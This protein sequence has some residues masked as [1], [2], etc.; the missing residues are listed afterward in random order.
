MPGADRRNADGVRFAEVDGRQSSQA[1]GKRVVADA[2]RFVDASLADAIEGTPDWR[3]RYLGPVRDLV[4]LGTRSAKDALRIAADGLDSLHRNVEFAYKDDVVPVRE[5]LDGSVSTPFETAVLQ[6]HNRSRAGELTIPYKGEELRGDALLGRL[7]RWQQQGTLEPSAAR[8]I[9]EVV[10]TPE[11]LDLSD[12]HVVLLGAAAE[13]GPLDRLCRWGANVYAVDVPWPGIWRRIVASAM[14]GGGKLHVPMRAAPSQDPD[15]IVARGGADIL[16]DLPGLAAWLGGFE[17]SL[18]VG[19]YVYVD[20]STFVLLAAAAD[21]LTEHLLEHRPG[22]SIAYLATPT[23]VFAV[24]PEIVSSA[25][26]RRLSEPMPKRMLRG[27]SG[28]RL[29]ASSYRSTI[30]GEDGREWGIFDCLVPQQGAN[31]ALAKN[32]QKWR[33]SVALDA[34]THVSANVAPATRTRSV[35]KNRIL[36]AA[37][38]GAH[39]FGVEVFEPQTSRALM[40]AL[41]IHDLRAGT[42]PGPHPYDLFVDQAIHGGLWNHPHEPRSVLPLAV[43]VGILSSQA[44]P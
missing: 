36:A 4:E 11:W 37:Y 18:V 3:K 9:A 13:M 32:L 22:S 38:A 44:R 25:H 12:I 24:T 6:G 20:G 34:G 27:L 42:S 5:A 23:D 35:T 16:T 33:A 31:Y 21:V 43:G 17:R 10:A 28:A 29:F 1:A 26:Q 8:A 30:R 2:A 7:D 39:R 14:E 19:N 41:L 40:A 15:E